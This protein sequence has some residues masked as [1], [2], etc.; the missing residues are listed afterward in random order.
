MIWVYLLTPLDVP[1][2]NSPAQLII[3]VLI[4][5]SPIRRRLTLLSLILTRVLVVRKLSSTDCCQQ[6][7]ER[8]T[9]LCGPRLALIE[10]LVLSS[11]RHSA[12]MK[13]HHVLFARLKSKRIFNT[14]SI[15]SI[16]HQFL[17]NSPCHDPPDPYA[18]SPGTG[19]HRFH[20]RNS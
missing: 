12:K 13:L 15:P 17:N 5:S 2:G 3:Q 7:V 1:K 9:S 20:T 19:L 10:H 11:G 16:Q 8:T 6:H 14:D 18:L 4:C